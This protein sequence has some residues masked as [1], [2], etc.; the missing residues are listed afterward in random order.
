MGKISVEIS[1]ELENKIRKYIAEHYWKNPFGKL[2][3]IVEEA[4]KLWIEK[5]IG[6]GKK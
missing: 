4:L 1:D 3:K 2:S 5:K 6:A